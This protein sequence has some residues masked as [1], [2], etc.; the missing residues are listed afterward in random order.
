MANPLSYREQMK[1]LGALLDMVPRR[2]YHEISGSASLVETGLSKGQLA[3][4]LLRKIRNHLLETRPLG[5]D[6][7]PFVRE[8]EDIVIC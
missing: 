6:P 2:S 7:S 4:A 8:I 5:A 3:F 1:A